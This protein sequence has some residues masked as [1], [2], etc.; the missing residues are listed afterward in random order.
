M[1][2]TDVIVVDVPD[3]TAVAK[4]QAEKKAAG[5]GGRGYSFRLNDVLQLAHARLTQNRG[6]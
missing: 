3:P 2:R 4:K 6:A 1:V 5:R